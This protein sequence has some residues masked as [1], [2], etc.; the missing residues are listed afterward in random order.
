MR[1]LELQST[2][3]AEGGNVF[4]SPAGDPLTTRIK[5][6]DIES[7]IRH[8]E[9]ITG[10]PLLSNLLGSAGHKAT[11]GDLDIAVD[12][13]IMSKDQ[14]IQKLIGYINATNK[15]D[16]SKWIKK[17]GI[18]VHFKMPINNDPAQGFVQIDFM[19]HRGGEAEARWIKFSMASEG[20]ASRYSGADRNLLMSSLAKA[21]GLKY[22]WQKGL[23]RRE[24]ESPISKD[25]NTIATRL[26]G[27]GHR[28]DDLLSVETIQAAVGANPGLSNK[29][30]DLV[31][32]LE[33]GQDSEGQPLKPGDVRKNA[34]EAERLHRLLGIS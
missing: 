30:R 29:L 4:K 14:L 19:F 8:L 10:L 24:D 18:S 9:S 13:E 11:S 31:R 2:L 25:P 21:Q 32:A 33:S 15:G 26:L 7:T 6:E 17:S 27:P 28:A 16:P 12:P 34:E 20:D 1:I 22:S 3:I 5:K 23:I